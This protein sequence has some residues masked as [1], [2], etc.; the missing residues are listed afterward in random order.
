M[1]M[2]RAVAPAEIESAVRGENP[3]APDDQRQAEVERR[4]APLREK[5]LVFEQWGLDEIDADPERC[6]LS[7]SPTKVFRIQA[8]VLKKEGYTE[9]PATDAG[10]RGMIG[11]LVVDRTLG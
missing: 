11:E 1:R 5:G 6:G 4:L 9:V 8:I 2:K 10:I 3:K 7:G